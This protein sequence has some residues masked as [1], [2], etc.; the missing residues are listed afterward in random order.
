MQFFKGSRIQSS[1]EAVLNGAV[2]YINI[3]LTLILMHFSVVPEITAN[4]FCN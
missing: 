4:T 3:K 2:A 1:P